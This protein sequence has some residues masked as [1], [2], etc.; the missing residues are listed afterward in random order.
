MY[1]IVICDDDANF[2]TYMENMLY[3]CGFGKREIEIY[4]VVSGEECI[5]TLKRMTAC[6]LLILDMQMS[7]MDG[8]A[9]A[10]AFRSIFPDALLVFC[11]G[12]VQPTDESFKTSPFRYLKKAYSDEKMLEELKPVVDKMIELKK[13]PYIIGKN[14]NNTVKLRPNDILFI[15]NYKRGSSIYVHKDSK[16]YSFEDRIT[17]KKKLQ[18]LYEELKDFGFEYAHNSYIVNLHY[19]IKFKSEGIIKLVDGLE[20]NV[21]RSKMPNFRKELSRVMSGK[22]S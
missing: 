12:A 22:Y 13:L 16:D 18:E 6:D 3:A 7:G 14:H 10:K 4:G 9:T 19:V 15:E 8:H 17:T 11:S 1:K 21:S 2:I 5:Q 20:L